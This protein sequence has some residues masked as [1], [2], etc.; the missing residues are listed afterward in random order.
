MNPVVMTIISPRKE[1]WP[2][3]E[4]EQATSCS[5]VRLSYG[6][7]HDFGKE[8]CRKQEMSLKK[9]DDVILKLITFLWYINQ[10]H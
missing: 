3:T 7:L 9:T 1:Y 10:C 4:I 8:D 2:S 5:Q 6:S